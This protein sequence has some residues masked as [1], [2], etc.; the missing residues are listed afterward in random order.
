MG[1]VLRVPDRLK[2]ADPSLGA[3][4]GRGGARAIMGSRSSLFNYRVVAAAEL[5]SSGFS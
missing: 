5:I 3:R 1:M 2:A 4:L